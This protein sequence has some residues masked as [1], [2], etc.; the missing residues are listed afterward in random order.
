MQPSPHRLKLLESYNNQGEIVQ[1]VKDGIVEN[2]AGLF[3]VHLNGVA[4]TPS[5]NLPTNVTLGNE[6]TDQYPYLTRNGERIYELNL[7]AGGTFTAAQLA[8]ALSELNTAESNYTT[9]E[10]TLATARTTLEAAIVANNASIPTNGYLDT[11]ATP[12]D[13]AVLNVVDKTFVV[14]KNKLPQMVNVFTPSDILEAFVVM[15]IIQGGASY[16]VRLIWRNTANT[17]VGFNYTATA[18]TTNPSAEAVVNSS[19]S[20]INNG[21]GVAPGTS[22]NGSGGELAHEITATRV[23][24][25]IHQQIRQVTTQLHL[26]LKHLV[27]L[28]KTVFIRSHMTLQLHLNCQRSV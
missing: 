17:V 15:S 25:G 9:A 28:T 6:R 16:T 3:T 19:V 12:N 4:Q 24:N 22:T 27:Q 2:T 11:V 5:V 26:M 14:N 23:G 18:S 10:T 20:L 7:S 13:I 1:T 21:S 8:T